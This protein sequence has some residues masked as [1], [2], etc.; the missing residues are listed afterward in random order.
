M[1]R[2]VMFGKAV[3]KQLK[4]LQHPNAIIPVKIDDKSIQDDVLAMSILYVGVYLSV[5]LVATILLIALGVDSLS[6]FSGVVGTTGNVGPGLGTVGSMGN[7]H[8]IPA[9]GKWILTGTMLLGR[10]EIY[11]L[12]I[13][14][15]PHIW[16]TKTYHQST[17]V[18]ELV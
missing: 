10:L 4:L 6:A 3:G 7:F 12:I 1:D 2:L 14:F 9:I 13:F 11:G 5:V 17:T 16:K 15:L 8:H 18:R